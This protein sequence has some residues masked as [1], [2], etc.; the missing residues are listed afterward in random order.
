MEALKQFT[1]TFAID[2]KSA[3]SVVKQRGDSELDID[4]VN[5]V[6]RLVA[7]ERETGTAILTVVLNG[8]NT[9]FT[10]KT[11]VAFDAADKLAHCLHLSIGTRGLQELDVCITVMLVARG[12]CYPFSC[13]SAVR[14][15]V[16]GRAP[17]KHTCISDEMLIPCTG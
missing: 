1:Y 9:A 11:T 17:T 15:V 13:A 10:R 16:N 3:L 2:I 6:K 4:C 8:Q 7:E 5:L 14:D 12:I